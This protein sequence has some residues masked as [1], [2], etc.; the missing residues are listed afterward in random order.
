[1]TIWRASDLWAVR[2]CQPS[3]R[4][5]IVCDNLFSSPILVQQLEQLRRL[6]AGR[7]AL[8]ECQIQKHLTLGDGLLQ[9][10]RRRGMECLAL[11]LE[12]SLFMRRIQH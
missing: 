5:A 9:T 4:C 8:R 1:M 11:A 2:K 6:P 12:H 7:L 10:A 3:C